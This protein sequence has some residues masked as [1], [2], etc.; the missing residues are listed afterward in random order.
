ME[1]AKTSKKS[2]GI[3]TFHNTLNFG[4]SLQCYALYKTI[5]LLKKDCNVGIINHHNIASEDPYKLYSR[6]IWNR[7]FKL[8]VYTTLL[9]IRMFVTH[10]R[11]KSFRNLMPPKTHTTTRLHFNII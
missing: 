3:V 6:Y 10:I 5:V 7:T 2:I 11:F 8:L 1:T 4:A 9:N